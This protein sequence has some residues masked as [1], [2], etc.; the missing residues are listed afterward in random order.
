M[1]TFGDG[2]SAVLIYGEAYVSVHVVDRKRATSP[3]VALPKS[4]SEERQISASHF[5]V[6]S[7]STLSGNAFL[8]SVLKEARKAKVFQGQVLL[9]VHGFNNTF[10]SALVAAAQLKRD[11]QFDGPV[12]VFSWP[13][14]GVGTGYI[15]DRSSAEASVEHLKEILTLLANSFDEKSVNWL[16]HSMGSRILLQATYELLM[17]GGTFGQLTQLRE[18][19][20]A[21]PAMDWR[22]FLSRLQA[23]RQ[24]RKRV[25][26][27]CNPDDEALK[28]AEVKIAE[29]SP[30]VGRCPDFSK[31]VHESYARVDYLNVKQNLRCSFNGE[32]CSHNIYLRSDSVMDD[33][34]QLFLGGA[35]PK[36][37]GGRWDDVLIPG[38]ANGAAYYRFVQ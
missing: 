27:Y 6:S 28:I 13:S 21:S 30:M 20:L 7:V 9:F 29:D 22:F 11:L 16:A 5:F 1:R 32:L 10:E 24:L 26:V 33:L 25:T 35:S 31:E 12:I 37:R 38:V 17:A 34:H 3:L 8:D 4:V 19:V 36:Y 15:R 14:S 23:V 2:R 18:I